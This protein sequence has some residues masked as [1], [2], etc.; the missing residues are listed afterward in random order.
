MDKLGRVFSDEDFEKLKDIIKKNGLNYC[1]EYC[2]KAS[3]EAKN[4]IQNLNL[5]EEGKS[6]LLGITDF[7][8]NKAY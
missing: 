8:A 1:E 3:E 6:F 4:I 5:R 7:V 2:I